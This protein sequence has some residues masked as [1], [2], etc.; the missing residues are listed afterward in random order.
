ML[1]IGCDLH[2]RCQEISLLDTST[3]EIV[4]KTLPHKEGEAEKFYAELKEKAVVGI[5]ATG[6]T[7]WFERLLARLGHELWF[8]DPAQIRARVVRRQKTD[9]RD[10]EHILQ[11]MVEGRFPRLWVPSPQ[12]RDVRQLLKHRDKL[13]QMQTSVKNQL[14]YLAMSQ[15]VCRKRQLW[16]ERGLAELQGLRLDPWAS[17]RREELLELLERLGPR[18]QELDQAVEE[19]VAQRPEA[20]LLRR[21]KGVGPITALAFVLTLG[22]VERFANSRKLVSYLGLNPSEDSSGGRQRLG[23]ISKQGNE[24]LGRKGVRY[25]F[26]RFSSPSGGKKKGVRYPFE[27]FPSPSGR[28]RRVPDTLLPSSSLWPK[29]SPLL[30]WQWRRPWMRW[31]TGTAGLWSKVVCRRILLASDVLLSVRSVEEVVLPCV[32]ASLGG[33]LW[34]CWLVSHGLLWRYSPTTACP[35]LS[36]L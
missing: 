26:E 32:Q 33:G 13:V 5:E 35:S 20:I 2:T 27:R 11:L 15:G 12:E 34:I 1:I 17:R 24:M 14:H 8:G 9:R 29:S 16:S 7:Q 25:P 10:A 4:T 19:E 6:Y 31:H 21:Q 23:H 28:K 3:G 22:P 36:R 18:I 30:P